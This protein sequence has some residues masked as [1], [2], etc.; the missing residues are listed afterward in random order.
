MPLNKDARKAYD[1]KKLDMTEVSFIDNPTTS[2]QYAVGE[3]A[4]NCNKDDDFEHSE[5]PNFKYSKLTKL[6]DGSVCKLYK[7]KN[8]EN[9]NG[10]IIK[11]IHKNEEWRSELNIL[12]QVKNQSPRLLNLIDFYESFRYA[13]IVAE[14]YD[15]FDL[16]EHIDINIPYPE[17]HGKK[18]IREMALCIKDCHDLGIAHLDIKC[19]NFVVLN[20]K[21]PTLVLIDF[22]HA[23]KIDKKSMK[24][25]NHY[26]TCF[27]ICPEGYRKFMSM[28]S[29]IWSLAICA[30]LILTGEYPFEG[31]HNDMKYAKNVCNGNVK[32]S[33]KLSKTASDFLYKCLDYNPRTRPSIDDVILD[34]FLHP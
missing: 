11:K 2:A 6:G 16:Y 9:G 3:R 24:E 10:V 25:G 17:K 26:G 5:Y 19:E 12:K 29:D 28:K 7:S 8:I 20:N 1:K 34:E 30:H 15:G 27:Y 4:R 18:L 23:E 31:E 14:L 21:K 13:Y 32:I 33:K 22:G